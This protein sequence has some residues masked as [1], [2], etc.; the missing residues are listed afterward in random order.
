MKKLTHHQIKILK[1][2]GVVAL[3]IVCLLSVIWFIM[4]FRRLY[5][6]GELQPTYTHQGRER[7]YHSVTVDTIGTWMTFNYLNVVFKLPPTYLQNSL[8]ITDKQYPNV[9]IDTYIKRHGLSSTAFL[10]GI[11]QAITS[12]SSK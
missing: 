5:R 4:S 12:Y 6:E 8:A 9:R 3:A 2:A 11:R 10:A 1:I 7:I